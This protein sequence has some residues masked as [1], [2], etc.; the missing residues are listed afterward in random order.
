MCLLARVS[1]KTAKY[2]NAKRWLKRVFGQRTVVVEAL[3]VAACDYLQ[4]LFTN[5]HH[6][7]HH[8]QQCRRRRRRDHYQRW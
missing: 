5:G 3:E 8:Q 1:T 7:H 2:K 4:F 6:T